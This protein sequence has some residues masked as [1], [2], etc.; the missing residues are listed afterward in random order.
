MAKSLA[1]LFVIIKAKTDDFTKG[2]KQV[3]DQV[4]SSE[5]SLAGLAGPLKS[6]LP[7][8]TV[9]GVV[10]GIGATMVKAAE[11]GEQLDLMR[12]KTGL[13]TD[14]LQDLKFAADT[15]GSS[16]DGLGTA[17]RKLAVAF[18]DAFS[19]N[20][21]A[22]AQ[23]EKLGLSVSELQGMNVDQRF[24]AVAK[25]IAL[26]QDPTEKAA[27]AVALFGKSGMDMIP[28]I[29]ALLKLEGVKTPKFSEADIKALAAGKEAMEKL[30]YA[31]DIFTAKLSAAAWPGVTT[32]L[33]ALQGMVDLL[34]Q[35]ASAWNKLPKELRQIFGGPL[36]GTL[37]S[38]EKPPGTATGGIVT[39]P[40]V[41]LVGEAGPEAI[42][43]LS[44]MS[45]A[46]NALTVNIGSYYGDE[47]SKR[48][49][50]RDIQRILN[51]ENRRTVTP[52]TQTSYYSTGGHL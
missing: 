9:A 35:A 39:S 47:M 46:G 7:A 33:E 48:A 44:K 37:A 45:A 27:A 38:W 6:I 30:A 11:L 1:E 14:F 49:L 17:S 32:L 23:F 29:D 15:S 13:S 51:E 41:R 22:V 20:E 24:R 26:I 25:A 36:A 3:N 28:V 21:A 42:I 12:Q 18:S 16:L 8:A 50:V 4:K 43:P 40:Q 10:A 5:K 2:M 52:G 19:G 34:D 31:W